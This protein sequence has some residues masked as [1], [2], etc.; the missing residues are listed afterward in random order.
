MVT[1]SGF[2]TFTFFYTSGVSSQDRTEVS[3]GAP[4]PSTSGEAVFQY[5]QPAK[6]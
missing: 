6:R 5:V 4:A 2:T 1:S 3:F